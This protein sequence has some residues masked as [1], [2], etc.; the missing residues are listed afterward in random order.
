MDIYQLIYNILFII[1]CVFF[2]Y[3]VTF[4]IQGRHNLKTENIGEIIAIIIINQCCILILYNYIY[5]KVTEYLL[6]IWMKKKK[7][8]I[9]VFRFYFFSYNIFMLIVLMPPFL[10]FSNTEIITELISIA[11]AL[12]F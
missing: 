11:L 8:Y 3:G 5:P 2:V 7:E 12:L 10:N 4:S 1:S 6:K 9:K